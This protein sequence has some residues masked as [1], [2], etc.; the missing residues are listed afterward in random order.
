MQQMPFGHVR[1][2]GGPHPFAWLFVLVVIALVV[3]VVY[4]AIRYMRRPAAH[5]AL[6]GGVPG[7]NL[8]AIVALRYA[9]GEI[10]RDQYLR[11]SADLGGPVVLAT[12][13]PPAAPEP[14]PA[15]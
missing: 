14:P 2:V 10:E 12:P 3:L 7:Q 9:N 1:N 5:V 4:W 11:M 15:P 6:A 13:E 8:L